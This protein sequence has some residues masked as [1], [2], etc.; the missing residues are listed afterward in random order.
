[1]KNK[2]IYSDLLITFIISI[3]PSIFLD[4]KEDDIFKLFC[5]NLI[6]IYLTLLPVVYTSR[7]RF[8]L[9]TNAPI[10]CEILIFYY[11][12]ILP[13]TNLGLKP[14]YDKYL[15]IIYSVIN[16]INVAIL[17]VMHILL[18]KYIFIE[19]LRKRQIEIKDIAIVFGT[20]LTIAL[21]FGLIYTL[22]SLIGGTPCIG[23]LKSSPSTLAFYFDHIYFSFVTI[24]T[25]GYGDFVPILGISR[26]FAV[27]EVL[28]GILIT[29][30]VLGLIISSGIFN[31][32][33]DDEN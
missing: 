4:F 13:I 1:M 12:L 24:T 16:I 14:D 11:L 21:G 27:T 20:Y 10:K 7:R 9:K 32:N 17:I 19:L 25:V 2:P 23:N 8:F 15:M 31:I 22:I 18:F 6:K 29:N 26:F 33:K 30:I 3:I 28:I 5:I